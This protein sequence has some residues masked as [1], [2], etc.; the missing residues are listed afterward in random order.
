GCL[1]VQRWPTCP[2]DLE[3]RLP[4]LTWASVG[5]C[6]GHGA[7]IPNTRQGVGS[8]AYSETV[9]PQ[10]G[11][12]RGAVPVSPVR[13]RAVVYRHPRLTEGLDV[14]PVHLN[15]VNGETVARPHDAKSHEILDRRA[16]VCLHRNATG[17]QRFGKRARALADELALRP[18]LGEVDRHGEP[19]TAR[20]LAHRAVQ[21][22]AHRVGR[23][24]RNTQAQ[25]RSD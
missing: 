15:A 25:V 17:A 10:G 1:C 13:A 19:L 23:V 20:E 2:F 14:R 11:E 8:G 9:P 22:L 7:R 21:G 16:V 6:P 24:G 3:L 18:R 4:A 5:R 12:G